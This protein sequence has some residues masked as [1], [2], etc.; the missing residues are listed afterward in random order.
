MTTK[1]VGKY[2]VSLYDAYDHG[3]RY[4]GVLIEEFD[5]N[6]EFTGIK[7]NLYFMKEPK[8]NNESDV[9]RH[10]SFKDNTVIHNLGQ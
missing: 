10:M 7:K 5:N 2:N 4:V 9:E 8:F 3:R 6:D 1:Q